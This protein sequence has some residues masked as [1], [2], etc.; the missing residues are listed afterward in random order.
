MVSAHH[1]TRRVSRCHFR[2]WLGPTFSSVPR[3]ASP[4]NTKLMPGRQPTPNHSLAK[5]ICRRRI[6]LVALR[7]A[8]LDG[9]ASA[10]LR[11][12]QA[13]TNRTDLPHSKTRPAQALNNYRRSRNR[14][15]N[16]P[17]RPCSSTPRRRGARVRVK[18]SPLAHQMATGSI[19]ARH[20]DNEQMKG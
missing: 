17:L 10:G 16:R 18:A 2:V 15:S 5:K 7:A 4:A 11:R 1:F 20:Y 9:A 13:T 12:L 19:S 8:L 6:A 14:S 3:P